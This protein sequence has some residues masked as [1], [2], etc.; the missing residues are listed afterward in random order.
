MGTELTGNRSSN[1]VPREL[2][3]SQVCHRRKHTVALGLITTAPCGWTESGSQENLSS[4]ETLALG[5][6]WPHQ[7]YSRFQRRNNVPSV[8]FRASG[9]APDQP[10]LQG[11]SSGSRHIKSELLPGRK[12]PQRWDTFFLHFDQQSFRSQDHSGIRQQESWGH[13][14]LLRLLLLYALT[15]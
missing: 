14:R 11:V 5:H 2:R 7:V 1:V 12:S 13:R 8:Y 9:K 10:G 3:T 6:C 15:M 4:P